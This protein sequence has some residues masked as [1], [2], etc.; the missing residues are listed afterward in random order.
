MYHALIY[1]YDDKYSRIFVFT[2]FPE[3]DDAFDSARP[4]IVRSAKYKIFID[5]LPLAISEKF[6]LVQAHHVKYFRSIPYHDMVLFT[7]CE[8][9]R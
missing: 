7:A 3:F 6:Q 1:V 9:S 2:F 8:R 4:K 5:N